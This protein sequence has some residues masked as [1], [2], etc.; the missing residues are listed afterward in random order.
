MYRAI[1][2]PCISASKPSMDSRMPRAAMTA[3]PGTPGAATMV[4]PSIRMKGNILP[5]LGV[6]PSI[7][8]TAMEQLVRVMVEPDR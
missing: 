2:R 6:W 1:I 8:I 3:P 4:M 5:K 7:I